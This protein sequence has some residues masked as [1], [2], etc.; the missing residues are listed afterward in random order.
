MPRA[1][2][3]GVYKVAFWVQPLLILVAGGWRERNILRRHSGKTG[4]A[5][6]PGSG[7]TTYFLWQMSKMVVGGGR[8]PK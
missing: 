6:L 1:I 3:G 5:D 2:R 8:A 4:A 7:A